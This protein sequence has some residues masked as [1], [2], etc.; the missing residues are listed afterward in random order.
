ML[1]LAEEKMS[2]SAGN[3][4]SLREV[5]DSY[6]RE[7]IL[8][9]F[10]G[11]HYRSPLDYSD[12]AMEAAQAQVEGFRNAF[13]GREEEPAA[14]WEAFQAALD[15]DFNTQA[16]LAVLHEWRSAGQRALLLRGLSVFGLASL[17]DQEAAPAEVVALATRRQEAREHGEFEEADWLREQVES[18]GW[19]VRDRPDGFDLVPL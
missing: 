12:E 6:G 13:R 4:V 19:E 1:R 2:K 9:Y 18:A 15:D 17:A 14:G 7:A 3:I 8:V 5:L 11:G 10:L 16:A